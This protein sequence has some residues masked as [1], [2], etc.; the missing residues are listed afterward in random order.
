VLTVSGSTNVVTL[1]LKGTATP[2]AVVNF[3]VTQLAANGTADF[4][5]VLENTTLSKT[6]T[7]TNP[8]STAVHVGAISVA[9]SAFSGPVGISAPLDIQPGGS[10]SFQVTFA[11][12]SS[13]QMTGSLTVDERTFVLTGLATV[14]ALPK[15]TITVTSQTA[16]SGQQMSVSIALASTSQTT[17]NGTLTLAFQPASGLPDDAAVQFLSGATRNATVTISPGDSTAKIDGQ[18]SLAFQTG[19]TAGN[20]VLTLTLPNSS[21]SATVTITPALVKATTATGTRQ[22]DAMDVSIIGFDNTH[23]V[24]QLSFTFYDASGNTLQPGVIRVDAT[25]NFKQ[26]YAANQV[27]G[28]FVLGATFPVT[29]DTSKIASVDVQISNSV[30][31]ASLQRIQF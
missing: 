30:G 5:S 26:Y 1:N 20:I 31:I 4:G 17:G 21:D 9:G 12:K 29:G 2:E 24:S 3:G 14:P 7:L 15:G 11:P 25:P 18:T 6:F 13:G 28:A 27:G 8:Y 19:T 10:S 16:V 22:I 23:S